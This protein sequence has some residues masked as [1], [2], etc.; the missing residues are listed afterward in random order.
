MYDWS[1]LV[2]KVHLTDSCLRFDF[3]IRLK[4]L[5]LGR[6]VQTQYGMDF[7]KYII[8][9]TCIFVDRYILTLHDRFQLTS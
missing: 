6:G 4:I 5:I 7:H 3:F 9:F 1:I 8:T 2:L